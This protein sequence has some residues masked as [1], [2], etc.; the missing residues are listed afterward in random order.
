LLRAAGVETAGRHAVVVGRSE[1]VGKPMAALL[2]RKGPGGDA[3]VTI[4]HSRTRN[5]PELTRQAE[6]LIAAIGQPK[7]ITP[8]MVQPG[9]VVLDVGINRVGEQL[10][11][12]VD[13]AVAE[14]AAAITPVPGGVGPMTIAML[15][16][17]TLSAAE[18]QTAATG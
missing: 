17:N 16:Q 18:L 12:D 7:F 9:A 11:G 5:L 2:V 13:P 10:V 6:I 8:D 14:I 15:L 4:C 1:I 3:T